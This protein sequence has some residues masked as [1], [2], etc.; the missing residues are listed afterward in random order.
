MVARLTP[1]QKVAC[2]IHV[3]FKSQNVGTL[4]FFFP[5]V[6]EHL[7]IRILKGEKINAYGA[8]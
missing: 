6:L 7:M 8:L 5:F 3:G 4:E 1:D 2:S